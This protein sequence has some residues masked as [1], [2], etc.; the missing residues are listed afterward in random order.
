MSSPSASELAPARARAERTLTG[1]AW[2]VAPSLLYVAGIFVGGSL[3]H[4]PTLHMDVGFGPDKVMHFLVFA[5][6][7]VLLYRSTGY[8]WYRS[9]FVARGI[10]CMLAATAVGAALELWQAT[11]P[12]RAMELGDLI[13]DAL[14]AFAA[15][16]V[17]SA[18]HVLLCARQRRSA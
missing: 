5:G 13:A 7:H 10:A 8:L 12:H 9:W 18:A 2:H 14:G 1:F 3:E 16:A 15:F 17:L 4:G 6:L 11:L